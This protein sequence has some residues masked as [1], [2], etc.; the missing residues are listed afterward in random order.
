MVNPRDMRNENKKKMKNGA[1]HR[2]SWGTRRRTM[3]GPRNIAGE[4]EEE[5]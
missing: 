1:P 5:W 4:R 2:Y 3:V